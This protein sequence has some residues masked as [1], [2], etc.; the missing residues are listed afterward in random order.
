MGE[1]TQVH[2]QVDREKK[3][4]W[5][6]LA[7]EDGEIPNGSLSALLREAMR[8]YEKKDDS[9]GAEGTVSVDLSGIEEQQATTAKELAKLRDTVEKMDSRVEDV[10]RATTT[11]NEKRPLEDRLFEALPPRPHSEQWSR[12]KSL[13]PEAPA[14]QWATAWSGKIFDIC[15]RVGEKPEKVKQKLDEMGVPSGEIDGETRYWVEG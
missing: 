11:E 1:K 4:K 9:R 5:K 6:E 10:R 14:A 15:K 8:R 3:E 12:A 2:I 7:E 13:D